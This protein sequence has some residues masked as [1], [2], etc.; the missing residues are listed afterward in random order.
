MDLE[1][2][3]VLAVVN[4]AVG[5]VLGIGFLIAS[6]YL[7]K[8]NKPPI[9]KDT[10]TQVDTRGGYVHWVKGLQKV[11]PVFAWAGMRSTQKE[12]VKAGGKGSA[13]G[14]SQKQEVFREDGM[15]V[16][17]VGPGYALHQII[18]NGELIFDGPITPNSHPSGTKVDVGVEG[19]FRIFW[20]E[21]TQPLNHELNY[22]GESLGHPDR[23]GINSRWPN[24]CY[25]H[26]IQKRLGT[27]PNWPLL[28]YVIETRLQNTALTTTSAPQYHEPT[29]GP[30]SG[31]AQT[32]HAVVNG[33]EDTAYIQV[34]GDGTHSLDPETDFRIVGNAIP[35]Q[36]LTAKNVVVTTAGS[37]AGV[38]KTRVYPYGGLAGADATG[39]I[40]N[41]LNEPDDGLNHGHLVAEVLFAA[42]PHG[43]CRDTK[44]FDM[45]SLNDL[46]DSTDTENLRASM[47]ASGGRTAEQVL[48]D[49]ML[50]LGLLLPIDPATGKHKAVLLR[51]PSGTLPD[52][53][54]DHLAGN[55]PR[56]VTPQY[57]TPLDA[58]KYIFSFS[59]REMSFRS[60]TI[61]IDDDGKAEYLQHQK[62]RTVQLNSVVSF[63]SAAVMSERRSQEEMAK[64]GSVKVTTNRGTRSLLPGDAITMHGFDEVLRV[65]SV[66]RKT[67]DPLVTLSVASDFYGAEASSFTNRRGGGPIP[68]KPVEADLAF[69]LHEL[70]EF[71]N[72]SGVVNVMIPRIRAH[73]QIRTAELWISR[74]DMT[75][76]SQGESFGVQTGGTLDVAMS[77]TDR[78]V[79]EQGPTITALGPDIAA[80]ADYSSDSTSWRLGKQLC[81]IDDEIFFLRNVT[82]LG[83]DTYRLDGL[84]R[85][86]YDTDRAAHASGADVF[87]FA[88]DQLLTIADA[89]VSPAVNLYAKSQPIGNGTLS[90][91]SVIAE[92]RLPLIGKG[93]VP[94]RVTALRVAAPFLLSPT[95]ETGDDVTFKWGH[96]QPRSDSTGAGLVGAGLQHG[97]VPITQD[98]AEFLLEVT[99]DADVVK[100]TVAGHTANVYIYTNASLVSDFGGEPASFKFKVSVLRGGQAST[101]Q[102]LTVTKV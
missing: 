28:D 52:V 3:P 40:D 63:A 98:G 53:T 58:D 97:T 46:A 74:D 45:Q 99:D 29:Q 84:I 75:Y 55:L 20:G 79:I 26:W 66:K 35:D 15:H 27:S 90:L 17:C 48:S 8:K 16:L 49:I 36:D 25:I 101:K 7:L 23:I 41:Y 96:V 59:D 93:V 34:L 47:V 64:G 14:G 72:T 4:L 39:T 82:A 38:V 6:R 13:L 21:L 43:A 70:P 42:W 37:P 51:E 18:Q 22:A 100:R 61:T 69:A 19:S 80:V 62:H 10:P 94:I 71:V 54:E 89:L 56:I 91:A 24:Y 5:L 57:V 2:Q 77:A 95:Y 73:D 68:Q 86:R 65:L 88:D 83:G 76:D 33:A 32:I 60:M 50:D 30:L 44:F 78:W 92:S 31:R 85:A 12:K 11:G 9:D 87:I 1:P 81:V 67:S 102:V